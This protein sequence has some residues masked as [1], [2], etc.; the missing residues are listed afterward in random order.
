MMLSITSSLHHHNHSHSIKAKPQPS[1]KFHS[2]SFELLEFKSTKK[3]IGGIDYQ[4]GI[5]SLLF[6]NFNYF[7][8]QNDMNG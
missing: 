4:K 5:L 1:H 7:F 3:D 6:I 8:P 2:K